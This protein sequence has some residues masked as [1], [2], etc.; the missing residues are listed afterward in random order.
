MSELADFNC[1]ICMG[2]GFQKDDS[3]KEHVEQGIL[4]VQG[5]IQYLKHP[6]GKFWSNFFN[7]SFMMSS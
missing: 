5:T 3:S 1:S 6:K 2:S 4:V 7:K